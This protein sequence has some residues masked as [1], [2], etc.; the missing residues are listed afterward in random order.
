[1][2]L[3]LGAETSCDEIRFKEAH[4]WKLQYAKSG[5]WEKERVRIMRVLEVIENMDRRVAAK[6]VGFGANTPH[7]LLEHPDEKGRPDID[8]V[9]RSTGRV[10]LSV[11]V[12]GTE[13]MRGQGLWLRPDKLEWAE[14]HAG[15]EVWYAF[16]YARPTERIFFWR[17]AGEPPRGVREHRIRYS[18]ERY[19]EIAEDDP[20]LMAVESFA[21]YLRARVAG[22]LHQ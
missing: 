16:H 2:N 21:I 14:R 17:P 22:E 5:A 13:Q 19:V 15:W 18:V 20:G 4:H 12:T 3:Q 6:V 7:L 1:M 11:E 9:L 10:L 8:V